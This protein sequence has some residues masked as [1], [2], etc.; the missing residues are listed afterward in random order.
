MYT[1]VSALPVVVIKQIAN[2]TFPGKHIDPF[3]SAVSLDLA[4]WIGSVH[5]EGC[6]SIS[7]DLERYVGAFSCRKPVEE[8]YNP[9]RAAVG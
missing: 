1:G 3:G 4:V 8:K 7:T 6:R 5:R 9:R 2:C